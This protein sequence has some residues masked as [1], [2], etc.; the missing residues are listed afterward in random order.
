MKTA[1]TLCFLCVALFITG[2]WIGGELTKSEYLRRAK[3]IPEKDYFTNRDIEHI[4]FN[5]PQI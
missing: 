4:L 5:E 2:I 3:E 1:I